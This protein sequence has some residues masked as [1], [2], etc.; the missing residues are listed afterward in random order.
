MCTKYWLN[1]GEKEETRHNPCLRKLVDQQ[2]K[3]VEP[4]L[5]FSVVT[6]GKV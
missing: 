4:L 2:V 6:S 1:P 5:L 3:E